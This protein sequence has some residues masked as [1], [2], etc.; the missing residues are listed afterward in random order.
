MSSWDFQ[1]TVP[2]RGAEHD[3][4]IPRFHVK[5]V[6]NEFKSGQ[7]GHD[8]FDE[9]E[10]VEIIVPGQKNQI[11]DERV[12][13]EH[14]QRWPNQYAAFKANLEPPLE[15]TPLKEWPAISASRVAELQSANIK[16]V[17][18]L[19]NLADQFLTKFQGGHSLREKARLWL[20]QAAGNQPL[21][22]LQA[23]NEALR[24][25]LKALEANHQD[26]INRLEAKMA[27]MMR[28]RSDA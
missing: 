6:K 15:G 16:T 13:N 23:E 7:A 19:A 14:R 10:Y 8:V 3:N 17:E 25:Q 20:E 1:P 21:M 27:E 26:Q 24:D 18:Q 2:Q 5:P 12:K 22:K 28:S 9:I 11:V 4:C